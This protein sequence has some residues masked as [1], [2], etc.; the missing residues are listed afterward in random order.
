PKFKLCID[1]EAKGALPGL[2]PPFP[3]PEFI[4]QSQEF[5]L[6]FRS[7]Y[8]Q[9]QDK[10]KAAF[11]TQYRLSTEGVD[12]VLMLGPYWTPTVLGPFSDAELTGHTGSCSEP[13]G[14]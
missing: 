8:L 10:A 2:M 7:I 13:S 12:W 11:K 14:D 6:A 4:M 5:K 9:A 1:V 3:L